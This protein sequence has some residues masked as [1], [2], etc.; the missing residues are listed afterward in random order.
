M[1]F[2]L[3]KRIDLAEDF[4]KSI[5]A[6]VNVI[7]YIRP[8]LYEKQSAAIFEPKRYSFIE[9]ST[10][11]G[12]THGC[13]VWIAEQAITGIEGSN[14]WWVAPV[15][16][17]AV[18]V[19]KRMKRYLK[20]QRQEYKSND[21]NATITLKENGA[22]I[23]FKSG[24]KPDN[25]YGED[26]YS[27]VLDEASRMRKESWYAIR[28][29]LTFTKGPVRVIGN[30]K[31]RKNWAYEMGVMARSGD[32]EMGYHKLTAYDAVDGG[33]LDIKEIEDAKRLLPEDVFKELYL[34]EPS[35]DAGN[36]FGLKAI[37]GCIGELS[38]EKPYVWGIDLAK[39][40]DFTVC[41][42]LDKDGQVCKF[43]RWQGPW[44]MT[45]ER[46]KSLVGSDPA[47]V[48]S[49]GVGDPILEALQREVGGNFIGYKFSSGSKQQLMEGLTVGIQKQKITYPNGPIV[50]ELEIFEYELTR[51]GVRYTAP[52]GMHDDAVCGLALA[53]HIYNKND[54]GILEYLRQQSE[55]LKDE[56]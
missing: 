13:M 23:W 26:V 29:T 7:P 25:L 1:A 2:A 34:A 8:H 38:T 50:D 15:Y 9:A 39:S 30:V 20:T 5:N 40:F 46:V 47:L 32:P 55:L 35:D 37:Q 31:G 28:S 49:T 51:T 41:I 21:T 6:V 12:K 3:K 48:D 36:P 42:A 10:K 19:Y 24:E 18:M 56:R 43:E 53:W 44:N 22:V 45:I 14:H 4:V 52:E 17:Q 33:I 11:V 16:A 54:I 27:A